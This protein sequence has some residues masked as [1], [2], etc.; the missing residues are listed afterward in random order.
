MPWNFHRF[1]QQIITVYG[2]QYT[3]GADLDFCG[4]GGGGGGGG[5]FDSNQ[6]SYF[7]GGGGGGSCLSMYIFPELRGGGGF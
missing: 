6:P 1:L 4:G 2:Q 5:G 7:I 3:S